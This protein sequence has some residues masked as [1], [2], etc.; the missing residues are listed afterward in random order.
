M[1]EV[2]EIRSR[3]SET[4]YRE[5]LANLQNTISH[6]EGQKGELAIYDQSYLASMQGVLYLLTGETDWAE[7]AYFTIKKVI[8]DTVYFQDPTSR[9]LTRDRTPTRSGSSG[10]VY[11]GLLGQ[12]GQAKSPDKPTCFPVIAKRLKR[13]TGN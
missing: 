13:E 12:K 7:K 8:E 9:G 2:N 10:W 1:A 5:I 11:H 6:Y 4:P 3:L